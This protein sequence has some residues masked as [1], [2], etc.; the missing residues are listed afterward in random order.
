MSFLNLCPT[1]ALLTNLET[2][3]DIISAPVHCGRQAVLDA[4]KKVNYLMKTYT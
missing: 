1:S 2:L 4:S 3:F